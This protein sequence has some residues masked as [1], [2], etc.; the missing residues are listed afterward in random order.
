MKYLKFTKIKV[1]ISTY[2]DVIQQT[3]D[4]F[5]EKLPRHLRALPPVHLPLQVVGRH[6]IVYDVTIPDVIAQHQSAAV[7]GRADVT[8]DPLVAGCGVATSNALVLPDTRFVAV[9]FHLR[10]FHRVCAKNN[11]FNFNILLKK[12]S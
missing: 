5:V 12:Y 4:E 11:I 7:P 10:G 6:A 1:K 2:S 8:G 3:E 9:K